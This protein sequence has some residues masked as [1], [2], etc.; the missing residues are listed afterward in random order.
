MTKTQ[1]LKL[2]C[3]LRKQHMFWDAITKEVAKAGFLSELTGKPLK[4]SAV[5]K[6][7]NDR[8]KRRRRKSSARSRKSSLVCEIRKLASLNLPESVVLAGVR[9]LLDG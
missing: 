5:K 9:A 2:I 6:M 8:N 3:S 7:F 1:A 4:S